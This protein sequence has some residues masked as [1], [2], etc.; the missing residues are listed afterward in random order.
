MDSKEDFDIINNA[1]SIDSIEKERLKSIFSSAY[2]SSNS[3]IDL[4]ISKIKNK[5][6][7]CLEY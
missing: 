5:I 7:V 3:Q 1:A 6:L 4:L 2:T